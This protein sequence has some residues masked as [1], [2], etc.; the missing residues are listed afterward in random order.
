[1]AVRCKVQD[2][3]QSQTSD[4]HSA[5]LSAK[6]S[7]SLSGLQLQLHFPLL[8]DG[9]SWTWPPIIPTTTTVTAS[10]ATVVYG[11]AVTFTATVTS[12]NG[13]PTGGVEFY[14]QTTG[15]DLGTG[16]PKSSGHQC[17]ITM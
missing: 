3:A 2:T 15:A 17:T 9:L 13:T 6:V 1:M 4:G 14:D 12:N 8:L 11:H 10:T 16:S 7:L 5:L